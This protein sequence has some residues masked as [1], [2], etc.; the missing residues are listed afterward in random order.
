MPLMLLARAR[1]GHR[2]KMLFAVA[3]KAVMA[4]DPGARRDLLDVSS[5]C[6]SSLHSGWRRKPSRKRRLSMRY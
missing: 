2:A 3:E 4:A 6:R 1:R 5:R